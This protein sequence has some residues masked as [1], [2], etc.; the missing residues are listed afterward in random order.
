MYVNTAEATRNMILAIRAGL[1]VM[2][3]GSPGIGKSSIA[4]EIAQKF[5]LE[6]IDVRLGQMDPTD[7]NGFPFCIDGKAQYVPTDLFP[8]EN[9]P[10]PKGK[11]GFFLFLDEFN[12]ASPA[13]M[14]ASYKLILDHCVGQHKLHPKTVI[15]CAGNELTDRAIVNR[16]GTAM[17]SRLIHL[18]LSV[19]IAEWV[20]W[21]STNKLDYRVISYLN[22]QP[23]MLH[24]FDPNH[25]DK[26]FPCPRTWEFV[27]K[28][29][30][31][32]GNNPLPEQLPLL[33]GTVGE[34]AAR[35]FIMFS[36]TISELPTIAEIKKDPMKAKLSTKPALLFAVSHMIAANMAPT[37]IDVLMRYTSRM[38]LEFE[39]ITLQNALYR[40]KT[41][42][43]EQALI[44]WMSE[45]EQELF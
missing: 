36:E 41:L 16:M 23:K 33:A 42:I 6:L 21:A 37:N 8:L 3:E 45:K 29:L 31:V 15:V 30:K 5:K 2:L 18:V 1:P 20:K 40:D 10:I 35:E 26:T 14:A 9:T 12:S 7:L 43:Q 22:S 38:S 44:D 27:S 24:N 25:D 39:T 4:R 11:N 17:E 34:G 32:I 28:L 13:V 19:D